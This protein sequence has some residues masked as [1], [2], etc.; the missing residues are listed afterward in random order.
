MFF[1]DQTLPY[2]DTLQKWL[3]FKYW[4]IIYI[5]RI[6]KFSIQQFWQL[7][8]DTKQEAVAI[9]EGFF[10]RE[11]IAYFWMTYKWNN[12]VYTFL[13]SYFYLA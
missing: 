10:H 6:K 7:K 9:H 3:L 4:S 1:D 12:T 11:L 8:H 13:S 2:V 5:Q